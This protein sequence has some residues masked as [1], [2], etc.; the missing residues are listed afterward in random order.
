MNTL[1]DLLPGLGWPMVPVLWT[2]FLILNPYLTS[3]ATSLLS[4]H[5]SKF[6]VI[7]GIQQDHNHICCMSKQIQCF[8]AGYQSCA[9][10]SQH[11]TRVRFL[12]LPRSKLRL[13]SANHRPGYW[14]N[15]PCDWPSTAWAYSEQE[16]ENRPCRCWAIPYDII[17]HVFR[18]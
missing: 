2:V 14:S 16:P 4:W 8:L 10:V 17:Q 18:L 5:L 12:S 11:G 6:K 7:C 15:L 9:S 1:T 13:C 3:V